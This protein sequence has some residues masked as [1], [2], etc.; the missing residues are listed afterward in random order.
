MPFDLDLEVPLEF[1]PFS[2]DQPLTTKASGEE[3]LRLDFFLNSSNNNA[4]T[5]LSNSKVSVVLRIMEET[6]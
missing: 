2:L 1:S 4:P 3:V 5:T 6:T